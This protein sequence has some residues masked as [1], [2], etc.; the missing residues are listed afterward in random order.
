[1][2][3]LIFFILFFIFSNQIFGQ[4]LISNGDFETIREFPCSWVE[5]GQIGKYASPWFS[6]DYSSPDIWSLHTDPSCLLSLM[7]ND[8][9]SFDSEPNILPTEPVF[10][11][12]G[13][14]IAG[15]IGLMILGEG[16][17]QS[18][19]EYLA[20]EL[21]EPLKS[22]EEYVLEFFVTV[23]KGAKFNING[24]G[25]AFSSENISTLKPEEV[26]VLKPIVYSEQILKTD[27]T[28]WICFKKQFKAVGNEK[29]LN[30]GVFLKEPIL[31]FQPDKN[32]D[33]L[34][35]NEKWDYCY[36]FI[37]DV[38]LSDTLSYLQK[39]VDTLF[40]LYKEMAKAEEVDTEELIALLA[41]LMGK[42]IS[43]KNIHFNNNE[44]VLLPS[45][46]PVLDKLLTI[47]RDSSHINVLII[48]H[49]DNRGN[50][51]ANEKLSQ[52]RAD[53]LKKF[54]QQNGIAG[55]RIKTAGYGDSQPIHDNETEDGRKK[56]RRVEVVFK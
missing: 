1:M 52:A 54:L 46:K 2:K 40:P 9:I 26:Q 31:K 56:N 24:L 29:Y 23:K 43:L 14:N 15:F 30:F 25:A 45:S 32:F 38:W 8:E 12:S 50:S 6:T 47:M 44:S 18:A 3:N 39:D 27:S 42:V 51:A 19:R 13:E 7:K 34:P 49:T 20:I 10:P 22:G 36:F 17:V 21:K 53:A 11:H 41:S 55:E 5:P 4:N 16:V 33:K 28:A 35:Q 37:D 48:G